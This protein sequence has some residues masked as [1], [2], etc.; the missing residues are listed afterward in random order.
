MLIPLQPFLAVGEARS[1]PDADVPRGRS[2]VRVERT[3]LPERTEVWLGA[4]DLGRAC[5]DGEGDTEPDLSG[6]RA[7][8]RAP[9]AGEVM[10]VDN[11][12]AKES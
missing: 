3:L 4:G 1:A 9:R 2:T 5:S 8:A 7:N 12:S 11:A 10:D 6:T